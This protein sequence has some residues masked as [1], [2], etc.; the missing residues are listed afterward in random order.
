MNNMVI[1]QQLGPGKIA[2]WNEIGTISFLLPKSKFRGNQLWGLEASW[3]YL[4][5]GPDWIKLRPKEV[6]DFQTKA[7]ISL[8]K[9][10]EEETMR[11]S[12]VNRGS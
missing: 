9:L 12:W 1:S 2:S 4:T 10:E 6:L 7:N 11:P 8:A 5:R 3:E